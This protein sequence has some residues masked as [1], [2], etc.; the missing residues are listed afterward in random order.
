MAYSPSVQYE[1]YKRLDFALSASSFF[2]F[3]FFCF[4]FATLKKNFF[5]FLLYKTPST[6]SPVL[7]SGTKSGRMLSSST[8]CPQNSGG[9]GRG[10]SRKPCVSFWI[11]YTL[12][13]HSS[14]PAPSPV[15][16]VLAFWLWWVLGLIARRLT[17]RPPSPHQQPP[18]CSL[19]LWG[20]FFLV[21]FT[22]LLH[23]LDA[24]SEGEHTVFVFHLAQYSPDPFI[25]LLQM[26]KFHFFMSE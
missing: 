7:W 5:F 8:W 18:V 22:G 14:L 6:D 24:A 16:M 25:V 2:L 3:S 21:L 17:P 4:D 23:V 11:R 19:C 20:C 9:S 12:S 15:Q 13:D 1:G 10:C 26:A